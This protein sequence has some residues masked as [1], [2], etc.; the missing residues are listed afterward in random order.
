[1]I[2]TNTI[3]ILNKDG[4]LNENVAKKYTGRNIHDVREDLL[5]DLENLGVFKEKVSYKNTVPVG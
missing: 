1:M 4:K 3:N 2:A 5:K